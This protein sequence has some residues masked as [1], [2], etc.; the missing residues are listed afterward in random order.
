M[1]ANAGMKP[2]NRAVTE[3]AML[4]EFAAIKA[5]QITDT[6]MEAARRSLDYSCRQ[7]YDVPSALCDFY[8]GRRLIG[9]NQTVEDCR[10]AIQSVTREQV[11]EAASH[12][13][14]GATFFL[15]GTL[16]GEEGEE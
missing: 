6:E 5:G 15:K 13:E 4:A 1:F 9:T 7:L 2:Q 12:F 8:D 11:V 14:H 3:E 10:L 16:E